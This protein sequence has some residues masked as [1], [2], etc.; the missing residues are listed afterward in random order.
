[1]DISTFKEQLKTKPASGIYLFS[2]KEDYLKGYYIDQLIHA[3]L[4]NGDDGL[5]YLHVDYAQARSL[6]ITDYLQAL[7][8]FAERKI[9]HVTALDTDTVRKDLADVVAL[10]V[11]DFPEYLIMI[12]DRQTTDPQIR[13]S[14]FSDIKKV[15]GKYAYELIVNEQDPELLKRWMARHAASYGKILSAD[16]ADYLLAIADNNMLSLGNELHK[17]C[18]YATAEKISRSDIDAVTISTIDAQIYELADAILAANTNRCMAC[19]DDLLEKFPDTM[20]LASV[21]NCFSRLYRVALCKERGLSATEIAQK[22]SMKSGTVN[23]NLRILRSMPIHRVRK[24]IGICVEADM[25]LKRVSRDKRK[26]MDVFFLR[27]INCCAH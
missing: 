11:T 14:A 20:V 12:F 15:A 4:P 5:N 23:K 16:A 2:G 6:D 13:S 10:F 22:L 3:V 21:Y 8:A 25:E 19:A 26:S 18:T 17:I 27:L 9:L 1:M 24:L 7:P